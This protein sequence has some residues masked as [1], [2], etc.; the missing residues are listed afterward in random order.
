MIDKAARN[1]L[2]ENMRHLASAQITNDEFE[3]RLPDSNDKAVQMVWFHG[4][5]QIYSH[6]ETH[7][8]IGKW[9]LSRESRRHVARWILFLKSD[10]EYRWEHRPKWLVLSDISIRFFSFGFLGSKTYEDLE[11]KKPYTGDINVWP[12]LRREDFKAALAKPPYL[13]R[14]RN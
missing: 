1:L 4:P 3:S 8:M 10:F 12:F 9:R 5:M 2:A 7:R 11:F 14:K 6:L 13:C